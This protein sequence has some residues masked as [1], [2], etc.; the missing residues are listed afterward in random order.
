MGVLIG[1]VEP[2]LKFLVA[3]AALVG[4]HSEWRDGMEGWNGV[5]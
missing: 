1:I 2:W 5:K 4:D 3:L